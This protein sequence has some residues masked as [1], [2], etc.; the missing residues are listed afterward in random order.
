MGE[1]VF[2]ICQRLGEKAGLHEEK[3]A[4]AGSQEWR[5]SSDGNLAQ[6]GNQ[7]TAHGGSKVHR[8]RTSSLFVG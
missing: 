2:K 6:F 5:A 8:K 3:P 4:V 7:R 1:V